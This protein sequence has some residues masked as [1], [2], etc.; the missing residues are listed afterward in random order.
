MSDTEGGSEISLQKLL[1][2]P[3]ELYAAPDKENGMPAAVDWKINNW[4]ACCQ[5]EA[6]ATWVSANCIKY[7]YATKWCPA[8]EWI[9]YAAHFYPDLEFTLNYSC[10]EFGY[11]GTFNAHGEICVDEMSKTEI[12]ESTYTSAFKKEGP[13][14]APVQD[15]VS[16]ARVLPRR[17]DETVEV[18]AGNGPIFGF[19]MIKFD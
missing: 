8:V 10:W 3:E 18:D 7:V 2:V 9:K 12:G 16:E 5:F 11:E 13:D 4:G 14:V 15:S 17:K 1:P 19:E 6:E